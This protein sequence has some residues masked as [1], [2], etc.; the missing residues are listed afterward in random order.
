MKRQISEGCEVPRKRIFIKRSKEVQ[1]RINE[2]RRMAVIKA[3]EILQVPFSTPPPISKVLLKK[4]KPEESEVPQKSITTK[5]SKYAHER[6]DDER[7]RPLFNATKNKVKFDMPPPISKVLIKKREGGKG[8]G[9][10]Y[11]EKK[12]VLEE[13]LMEVKNAIDSMEVEEL[14]IPRISSIPIKKRN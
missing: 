4:R 10:E 1:E 9:V 2:E 8:K 14:R 3:N 11:N 5:R 13:P 7:R 12:K 6:I